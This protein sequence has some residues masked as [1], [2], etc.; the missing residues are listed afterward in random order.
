M[1]AL[2]N[3]SW[4][5]GYGPNFAWLLVICLIF[6]LGF[7][8]SGRAN[9][10]NVKHV[11]VFLMA[12]FLAVFTSGYI[13]KPGNQQILFPARDLPS[14]TGRVEGATRVAAQGIDSPGFVTFGPYFP[15]RKG[16]YRVV[17]R[18][19]SSAPAEK[20][21][22]EWD[23]FNADTGIQIDEQ[24][25]LGTEGEVKTVSTSFDVPNWKPR[26]FE[27]RNNWNGASDILI[28]DVELKRL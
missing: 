5:Y 17:I 23:V 26:R 27:F 11:V 12:G 10:F 14:L 19:S 16:S 3:V 28:I 9:H 18:Y 20:Q 22:G 4:A 25:L 8:A 24:P 7:T 1:P 13:G 15:L 2:Y 6:A 21:I